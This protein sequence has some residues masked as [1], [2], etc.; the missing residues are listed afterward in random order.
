MQ[1]AGPGRLARAGITPREAEVLTAIGR[2]LTNREIAAELVISVRTVESHVSALLRKLDVA[3]RAGLTGLARQLPAVP[4][5]AAPATSFV[6][7]DG[8]LAEL[9]GLLT[10]GA[11]VSLV[12]PAGCGKT[13]LALETAR[14]WP[15]AA[16]LVELAPA[17][18]HDVAAL[19]AAALGAGY[20]AADVAAAARVALAGTGLLLIIDNG[21]HVVAAVRD[22]AGPLAR[23]VAGLRILVTS[24]EPLGL[25][26]ERVFGVPPLGLPAGPSPQ[27]VAAS[28]AGR[29]FLDRVQAACPGF[30][31][32][33]ASAPEV[34]AICARLDGL[35]LAI[36][37][38]TARVRTL[39]ATELRADLDH[40][41]ELIDGPWR[42]RHGSIGAAIEWSWQ[43][44]DDGQRALLSRLAALPGEFTL[45][46]AAAAA[47]GGPGPGPVPV[48]LALDRLADQSLVSVR[49][50][51]GQPARYRLLEVI[52]AF[53]R[54]RTAPE[55]TREAR[56]AHARFFAGQAEAAVRVRYHPAG[57][58][59]AGASPA[60]FDEPNILAALAWAAGHDPGLAGRLL[61]SVCQLAD[62]TPTRHALELI[63]DVTQPGPAH[64][65][66]GQFEPG[67][68]G[69]GPVRWS[70]EPL[71]RAAVSLAYLNLDDAEQR[72]AASGRV[73]VS[74]RDQALARWA[75]G[76]VHAYRGRE[77]P[78]RH[79]LDAVIAYARAAADPWLEASALQGRGMAR[80]QDGDAFADWADAVTRYA[81]SGDLMHA[82]N[83]RYM[84]AGRAVA[85]RTRL[86]EVPVWL[87]DCESYAASHGYA[88]EQAHVWLIR[89][90]YQVLHGQPDAARD[91]L[92]A[93]LPVF[94]QAGD[95]RC[96]S[97]ALL[98]LARLT[99][100]GDPAGAARLL[101]QSLHAAAVAPARALPEQILAELAG[102]AASAG[103]LV[104]AARSLGALEA[105]GPRPDAG[106]AGSPALR[107]A[108]EEPAYA[109]YLSEGR[110]GG[111]GVLL[112][113]YPG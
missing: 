36:E 96:V 56:A 87:D 111:A 26:T 97:R 38:A 90:G 108:R 81:V 92:G 105:L 47:P 73:A 104:L 11:L 82:S 86:R 51:D 76:W 1:H 24:R 22:V 37:L 71:A 78:A 33:A 106:P 27:E 14:R 85:T 12:G 102:T 8:V 62:I 53:A 39:G 60:G 70:T 7:R 35:P 4:P 72:A 77:G 21:E 54:S 29:L 42:G 59:P 107:R 32:D 52:R 57:P 100:P 66:T 80:A 68:P 75:S 94:R 43:L 58:A 15:G 93:A 110:A 30:R 3:D 98:D 5:I 34:A 23:A 55:V 64:P 67:K 79:D 44:L 48:R 65:R 6:G 25:D 28:P 31:L 112:A 13:R 103:D 83:V 89:A 69:A 88:H 99:R 49:L 84:L 113:L 10:P 2:R 9:A 61:V 45:A 20:E 50:P 95:F 74:E 41:F 16:R 91:L 17:A 19:V 101:I 63:R 40:R 18:A 109:G 46:L